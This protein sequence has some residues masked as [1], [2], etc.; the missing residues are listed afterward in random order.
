MKSFQEINRDIKEIGRRMEAVLNMTKP[1]SEYLNSINTAIKHYVEA[2]SKLDSLKTPPTTITPATGDAPASDPGGWLANMS[3]AR[4]ITAEMDAVVS[5]FAKF[6]EACDALTNAT[7]G[8]MNWENWQAD[9]HTVINDVR[10]KMIAQVTHTLHQLQGLRPRDKDTEKEMQDF[11]NVLANTN[12]YDIDNSRFDAEVKP[13]WKKVTESHARWWESTE[14]GMSA[15]NY[16]SAEVSD[17]L[18]MLWRE[19]VNYKT[20]SH[21]VWTK[22]AKIKEMMGTGQYILKIRHICKHLENKNKIADYQKTLKDLIETKEKQ[23]FDACA[24]IP[25]IEEVKKAVDAEK[26]PKAASLLS[27]V[28][29]GAKW[30]WNLAGEKG[31]DQLFKHAKEQE[32]NPAS[33]ECA[34]DVKTPKLGG[35]IPVPGLLPWFR[36]DIDYGMEAAFNAKLEGSIELDQFYKQG[37]DTIAHGSVTADV[38]ASASA[39]LGVGVTLVELVKGGGRLIMSA[40]A[41]T[42]CELKLSLLKAEKTIQAGASG[43]LIFVLS[44]CLEFSIGLSDWI[45]TILQAAGLKKVQATF[46]T[47]DLV[48][49]LAKRTNEIEFE[50]PLTQRPKDFK[51]PMTLGGDAGWTFTYPAYYALMEQVHQWFPKGETLKKEDY[52][53]ATK[54]ELADIYAKYGENK[55]KDHVDSASEVQESVEGLESIGVKTFTEDDGGKITP[56]DSIQ[57]SQEEIKAE[58]DRIKAKKE[59]EKKAKE[60]AEKKAKEEAE[61]TK[62]KFIAGAKDFWAKHGDEISKGAGKMY[63][64]YK[65]KD[66]TPEHKKLREETEKAKKEYDDAKAETNPDWLLSE[67][68]GTGA[69]EADI[70]AYEKKK[71]DHDF[72]LKDLKAAEDKAKKAY[73]DKQTELEELEQ[74]EKARRD[75]I[76]KLSTAGA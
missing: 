28:Y 73:T 40:S 10:I 6:D 7:A 70:T 31:L 76:E 11:I 72:K 23:F 51:V 26:I 45:Q 22:C 69:K 47:K 19:S 53:K 20:N 37:V 41:S 52:T 38:G 49:I 9:M 74:I 64:M 32:W 66:E 60:E 13:A 58:E 61:T 48:F 57:I 71:R 29:M 67:R 56:F 59:A 14:R 44:G 25:G 54:E 21:H 5:G 42:K 63:E 24:N 35:T 33:F 34:W 55:Q 2:K 15:K 43:D 62:G 68:P 8:V 46:K 17:E 12:F 3:S 1:N 65:N 4:T 39:H 18:S 36:F 50:F 75:H 16:I 30:A 27:K